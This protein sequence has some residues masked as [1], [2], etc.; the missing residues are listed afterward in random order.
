MYVKRLAAAAAFTLAL[1][2]VPAFA[3]DSSEP[4]TAANP[5]SPGSEMSNLGIDISKAGTT[6]ESRTQFWASMN[7]ADRATATQA[8]AD[9]ARKT[10]FTSDESAFCEAGM[11][12]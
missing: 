10:S 5:G 6:A 4:A 12:H 1:A 11:R 7:E 9:E 3:Q 2:A 8:C